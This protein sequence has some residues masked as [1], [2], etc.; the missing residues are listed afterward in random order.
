M[1]KPCAVIPVYNHGQT[2]PA[3]VAAVHQQGLPCVLV[4]DASNAECAAVMTQLAN[5]VD[6]FLVRLAVNQ[7]KGGAVMAGLREAA[8]LGFSHALQ[9]DADG[10]HELADVAPFLAASQAQ[11]QA[12]ICGYPQ[13][14][15]SVPKGRLYGRYLTHVWVWINSLSLAIRDSMCGFRVYPLPSTLALINSHRLGTRM[16][17]DPEIL[18]RLAWRNQ[19]MHWLPTRVHYPADGLSH[20]RLWQDNA[21]ISKMHAKLFFGMLWRAPAILWRRWRG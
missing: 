16:D 2:L 13:Y 3:V 19:P 11:P 9:V 4:D 7:G 15:A 17:F 10:Q 6:T 14:D 12:L 5:Q 20:F 1:H 21:L 8:R 18:V